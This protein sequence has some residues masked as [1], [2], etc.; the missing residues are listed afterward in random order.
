MKKFSAPLSV[1]LM[2]WVG[3]AFI[4]QPFAASSA[5]SQSAPGGGWET[6]WNKTVDAAKK[7]GQVMI[8]STPSSAL[9]SILAKAFVQKFG[10]KVDWINGRGEELSKR[11]QTEKSAGLNL[12][13][14]V[15]SGGTTTLTVMKPHGLLGKLDA[16][17]ILPEVIDPKNWKNDNFPFVDQDHNTMAM[18]GTL[19]RYVMYNT[20][21][22]QP[23][24]FTSYKD[25]LN[26][27]WKGKI[28]INDPTVAGTG[29]AFF[30]MLA[31]DVY[32]VEETHEFMRQFVKQEPAFTR[33]RRLQGEWIA[34]GKYAVGV[35][36]NMQTAV[37]FLKVGSPIAFARIK[38]GGKVGSGAGGLSI[39][40]NPAH[41]NAAKVFINWILS[42]EGHALFTKNYGSPGTRKDAPMEGIPAEFN[43]EPGEKFYFDDEKGVLYR[44]TMIKAAKE[45]LAPLF[46]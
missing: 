36:V 41:P 28:T 2:V 5:F 25:L 22:V 13:D 31:L 16:A 3:L 38:E 11:M 8:Y 46:K 45:I 1:L 18:V 6:E 43:P 14:V 26:P 29:S 15:M 24:E 33:N 12:V 9:L 42:S 34:K 44:G 39:A 4:C 32:G 7:E 17:L 35:A 27:K 37:D 40:A 10:I 23:D 19:Q 21:L 20:Q 30:T